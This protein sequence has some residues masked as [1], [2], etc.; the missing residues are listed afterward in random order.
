MY[1]YKAN[2][3]KVIDGDTIDA[4]IDLGFGIFVNK[5]IR[6]WG[7]DAPEVKTRDMKEKKRGKLAKKRLKSILEQNNG[8]FS[9]F[10]KGFGK[11]G[12]CL[13]EIFIE[14]QSINNLLIEEGLVLEYSGD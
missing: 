14:N 13:G 7:I 11:F 10:S 9:L 8:K 6:L 2:L 4:Q 1:K 12:R 5:R 3:L